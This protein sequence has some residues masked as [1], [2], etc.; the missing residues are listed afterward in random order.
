MR[1]WP[2]IRFDHRYWLRAGLLAGGYIVAAKLGLALATHPAQVTI[3]WPP[4]GIALATLLVLGKRYWPGVFVGAFV[5]NAFTFEPL[6]VALGIAVGNT[7]E[8]V[9]A[10]Y[11][12]KHWVGFR[13]AFHTPAEAG[14]YILVAVVSTVIAAVIGTGCLALSGLISTFDFGV[15]A[16]WWQGDFMGDILFGPLLLVYLMPGV[17][18]EFRRCWLEAGLMM[19]A[20]LALTIYVFTHHASD[21][22]FPYVLFPIMIWAATRFN[23][24]GAVTATVL[25]AVVAIWGTVNGMGPFRETHSMNLRLI[26]LQVY[27][28]VLS[29]TGLVLGLAM[30]KRKAAES[31]LRRQAL[32]LGRLEGEL[33][34]ANRRMTNILEG[35]LDHEDGPRRG[36]HT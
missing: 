16:T 34:E 12:L 3:V 27:L 8:A 20:S 30:A 35:V 33:K 6:P 15:L 21:W 32:E 14:F 25:M 18:D 17:F 11:I 10:A 2:S 26:N 1:G 4:S 19:A 5:S 23:Q 13:N 28:S 7:L 9:A 29:S 36:R 24:L 22:G 31:A